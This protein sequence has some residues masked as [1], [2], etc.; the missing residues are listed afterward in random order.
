MDED[1]SLGSLI[2]YHHAIGETNDKRLL[3]VFK[4]F[5]L[6]EKR[7]LFQ[8]CLRYL[9]NDKNRKNNKNNLLNKIEDKIFK[10][11]M[12]KKNDNNTNSKICTNFILLP[13]TLISH[14][15]SYLDQKSRINSIFCHSYIF[16]SSNMSLSNS[17]LIFNKKLYN[18]FYNS[19]SKLLSL[20]FNKFSVLHKLT[21]RTRAARDS[22]IVYKSKNKHITKN[23]Q[24]FYKI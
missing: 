11:F 21:I 8:Y 18:K 16:Y 12:N 23:L 9:F 14:T 2:Q 10:P 17:H 24:I 22:D 6:E 19:S 7:N 3:N 1:V 5:N 4:S 15:L 13:S 20:F